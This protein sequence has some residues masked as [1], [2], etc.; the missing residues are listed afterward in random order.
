MPVLKVSPL[1]FLVVFTRVFCATPFIPAIFTHHQRYLL[2]PQ[3][4]TIKRKSI[5]KGSDVQHLSW[6]PQFARRSLCCWYGK[7]IKLPL[8]WLHIPLRQQLVDALQYIITGNTIAWP[9][10][11]TDTLRLL[12]HNVIF[13]EAR[14]RRD[15]HLFVLVFVL[16]WMV[17]RRAA[18]L[19]F[20]LRSRSSL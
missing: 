16:R 20:K 6:A 8:W 10:G 15:L 19:Q 18:D 13:P 7:S 11:A 1:L 2:T 17:S 14:S 3:R 12:R 5:S 9:G 4:T